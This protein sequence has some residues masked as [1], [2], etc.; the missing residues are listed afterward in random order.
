M[1]QHQQPEPS[2]MERIKV[3]ANRGLFVCECLSAT[4]VV[5]LHRNLGPRYLNMQAAAGVLLI[6]LVMGFGAPHSPIP[7]ML[8]LLAYLLALA[9][10]RMECLRSLARGD[11]RHSKYTGEPR[12]SRFFPKLDEV[13]IKRYVEPTVVG[14]LGIIVSPFAPP[15]G[16]YLFMA[17]IGLG[18]S[19]ASTYHYEQAKAIA[20]VDS[21]I[22]A[23]MHAARVRERAGAL[24]N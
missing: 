18:V 8:F 16:F 15:L 20:A 23:R 14:L 10:A 6:I 12:L 17:A 7:M 19:V 11:L 2:A 21:L 1:H 9:A 3:N 4:V 13:T 5:F 22:D 24:L